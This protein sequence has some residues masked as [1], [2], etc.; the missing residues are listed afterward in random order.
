VILL[1]VTTHLTNLVFLL[2]AVS[3]RCWNRSCRCDKRRTKCLTQ[4]DYENMYTGPQPD[5]D[6]KYA[7]MVVVLYVTFL[8]SS[9]IPSLY[10]VALFYFFVT[11]WVDKFL[12]LTY[13]SKPAFLDESLALSIQSWFKFAI[14]LH[15]I[16]GI[17]MYSNSNIL[18]AY[19]D[20]IGEF[21]SAIAEEAS[22]FQFGSLNST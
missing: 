9:G 1:I 4:E 20:Q 5:M 13:Y 21:R 10:I 6:F 14:V 3:K 18:P 2:I 11:Y 16:G 7:S 22:K 15:L 17:L 12:V 19:T 8:Y